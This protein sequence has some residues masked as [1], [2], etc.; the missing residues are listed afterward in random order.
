MST[1]QDWLDQPYQDALARADAIAAASEAALEGLLL[2]AR[3][4]ED[5][6]VREVVRVL[7][8]GGIATTDIIEHLAYG[9]DRFANAFD[10]VTY[11]EAREAL[12]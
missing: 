10:L 7:R 12:P 4:D 6:A 3:D 5:G 1:H 11:H 2:R 8:K 9:S